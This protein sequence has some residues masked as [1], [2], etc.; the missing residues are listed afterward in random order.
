MAFGEDETVV[1]RMFWLRHRV[2]H[3]FVEEDRHHLRVGTVVK[4]DNTVI[5]PTSAMDEQE[6]G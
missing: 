2:A 5:V 6:V 1:G 3:H 4:C